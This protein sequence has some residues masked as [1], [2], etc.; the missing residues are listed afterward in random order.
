MSTDKLIKGP[1][2]TEI[3]TRALSNEWGRLNQVKKYGVK[4]TN[5]I[6]CIEQSD[7]PTD[8]KFTYTSFV[9]DH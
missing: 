2:G 1:D 6:Q 4:S 7:I 3:W 5:I 8:Q 9:R